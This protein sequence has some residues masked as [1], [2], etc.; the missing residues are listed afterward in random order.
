MQ[1]ELGGAVGDVIWSVNTT[2]ITSAQLVE[3][4]MSVS[5]RLSTCQGEF[6]SVLFSRGMTGI[7]SAQM[8]DTSVLMQTRHRDG[9]AQKE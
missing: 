8:E 6:H 9:V 2:Y 4:V 7:G 5:I 3:S 1:E